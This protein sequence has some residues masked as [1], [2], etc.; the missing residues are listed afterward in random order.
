ML[1][2]RR[3]KADFRPVPI[4][5]GGAAARQLQIASSHRNWL[6]QDA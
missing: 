2:P 4:V 5:G 1:D 3:E 6:T